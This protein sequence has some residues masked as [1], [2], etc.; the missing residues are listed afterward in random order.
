[1]AKGKQK[2]TADEAPPGVPEWVVTYGDMMSLLLT[3]FIMLVSLSEMKKDGQ[4]RAM[5][6]ALQERFGSTSSMN[7][8]VPGKSLQENSF[9]S[10]MKSSGNRSEDGVKKR[11]RDAA[12]NVGKFDAV[13]R[14]NQGTVVTI[15]G[16]AMFEPFSAELNASVI[17]N[18]EILAEVVRNRPNLI[19]IRGHASPEPLPPDS[20]YADAFALSFA[21]AQA[22]ANYFVQVQNL[23]AARLIV[24]AAG[25]T[26]PRLLTRDSRAIASNHRVDV[27][28]IDAYI[29]R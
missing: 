29:K 25:E 3:F 26:E 22:V 16:P 18:L 7:S 8:G 5:L 6:D 2:A 1:M 17:E 11:S 12:G 24:S 9:F 23:P 28:L 20:P 21:R 15:G 27:F 14:I 4:L 10:Q 13:N 19:C